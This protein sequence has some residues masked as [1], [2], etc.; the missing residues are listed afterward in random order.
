M[1]KYE[2]KILDYHKKLK[3]ISEAAKKY[4][5]KLVKDKDS[6][7]YSVFDTYK[8]YQVI[9]TF[10]VQR[11]NSKLRFIPLYDNWL[12]EDG[13]ETIIGLPHFRFFSSFGWKYEKEWIVKR[14]YRYGGGYY[15]YEDMFEVSYNYIYPRMTLAK[16]VKK[17]G[18]KPSLVKKFNLSTIKSMRACLTKPYME[19][20]AKTGQYY[21]FAY[22]IN[23][24][25]EFR[26]MKSVN[27][28]NRNHYIVKEA[29]T[30]IDY[31]DALSYFDKDLHNAYYVCPDHL[32]EAHKKWYSKMEKAKDIEK[33]KEEEEN[34]QKFRGA[35]FGICFGN[36]DITIS[37]L[38]S[39]D[40]FIAE[41][42]VMKHCVFANG[43]YDQEKHP[44]SLILSAKDKEGNRIETIEVNTKTFK[45]V[46]CF[47][48]QN[49]YTDHHRE[50]ISLVEENMW[51]IKKAC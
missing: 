38:K 39:V 17:H 22:L 14:H 24:N 20:L 42:R 12:D 21:L 2:Q 1:N 8:E 26:Y 3:P 43:Y 48:K 47:G 51:Q 27:I 50:I 45:V 23:T 25:N 46:Q 11:H 6:I 5:E 16:K 36:E 19:E 41:G 31:L 32:A 37:V 29:E 15:Y 7:W 28:C 10:E 30:W 33:A 35:F 49:C 9:R 13:K 18:W 34:Y 44:Y 4:A 40:D